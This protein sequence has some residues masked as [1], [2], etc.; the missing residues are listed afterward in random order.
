M[1]IW[2][3]TR[4]DWNARPARSMYTEDNG[5]RSEL[6]EHYD[7][8]HP[9]GLAGGSHAA[10]LRRVRH[11]QDFHLDGR[12]WSDIGYNGLVCPHGRAIEGR[13]LA[14]VGA[15]C[16]GHNRRGWGIQFMIGGDEQP[17]DAAKARMVRLHRDLSRLAGRTLQVLGHR[18]GYPTACPGDA[19][20]DWI[21]AGMPIERGGG[22]QS[23]PAPPATSSPSRPSRPAGKLAVDGVL[24]PATVRALQQVVGVTADG[25]MG[26]DTRR[27]LQRYLRVK[28]DGDLG[29]TSVRALQAWVGADVDGIWGPATTRA[30][31]RTLNRDKIKRPKRRWTKPRPGKTQHGELLKRG[32]QGRRV[33]R[34]QRGLNR[35]FPA[36]SDLAVDGIYGPATQRVVREFQRR[37]GLAVDG[38][39]GPK[40]RKA[41][42][43]Y[44]IRA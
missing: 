6:M 37:S 38:V 17:T 33:R 29:R 30:L 40:T 2:D 21:R 43:R 39:V 14:F 5:A 4:D 20:Y 8:G 32:D 27:A 42:A 34:L 12:G 25:I 7:G 31:Q 44:G 19:V 41:L 11:D 9:L 35:A 3:D 28:V 26:P 1:R 16:P 15:H 22:A 10:C 23:I 13:G 18:D 24:G 36:Y